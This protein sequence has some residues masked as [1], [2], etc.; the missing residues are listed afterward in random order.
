MCLKVVVQR[1]RVP[2]SSEMLDGPLPT[3]QEEFAL[4][5]RTSSKIDTMSTG[6]ASDYETVSQR[7]IYQSIAAFTL[8]SSSNFSSSGPTAFRNS[9]SFKHSKS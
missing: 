9:S 5:I 7:H 3:G 8:D 4:G 2:G 6:K 1:K